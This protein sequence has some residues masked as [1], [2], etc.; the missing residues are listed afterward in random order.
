MR[1]ALALLKR[2]DRELE[3]IDSR[4]MFKGIG[5]AALILC[6]GSG[7][8]CAEKIDWARGT[9]SV[10]VSAH[11][12]R[13]APSP[14]LARRSSESRARKQARL[15]LKEAIAHVPL[16]NNR[17]WKSLTKE[18][19]ARL[20]DILDRPITDRVGHHSDGSMTLSLS[21]PLEKL[22]TLWSGFPG[23]SES[24]IDKS[25]VIDARHLN[26]KPKIG[27]ELVAGDT[28]MAGNTFWKKSKKN[29]L[30]PMAKA[31]KKNKRGFVLP[32]TFQTNLN[33]WKNENRTVTIL[34]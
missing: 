18:Q 22:R 14:R 20:D 1:H 2:P 13:Q 24:F 29:F 19:S 11:G 4:L 21:L 26:A 6:L 10:H 7:Q 16:A 8:I 30:S 33:N 9:L 32:K 25:I 12:S 28:T 23:P 5:R 31:T 34:Y 17:N 15:K 27:M 3:V